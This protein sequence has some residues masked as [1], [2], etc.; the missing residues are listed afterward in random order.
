MRLMPQPKQEK[1]KQEKAKNP[2]GSRTARGNRNFRAPTIG[3]PRIKLPSIRWSH[4]F[5]GTFIAVAILLFL[6]MAKLIYPPNTDNEIPEDLIAP[7]LEAPP[8]SSQAQV[9]LT[10][11]EIDVKTG[12][13]MALNLWAENAQRTAKED[14]GNFLKIMF[15]VPELGCV[16]KY[17]EVMEN[18]PVIFP[19]PTT[20][21]ES[22]IHEYE[23][24]EIA[25][26][27][28]QVKVRELQ[29]EHLLKCTWENISETE[30]KPWDGLAP[31]EQEARARR[32]TR[33]LAQ[34]ID[35]PLLMS[36]NIA[37]TRG[38]GVDSQNNPEF[39]QFA[40]QYDTCQVQADGF[41]IPLAGAKTPEK[42]SKLWLNAY[43]HLTE[44]FNNITEL[45]FPSR[46]QVQ[47]ARP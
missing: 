34:S 5:K 45:I 2:E 36:T 8:I 30:T 20:R 47:P 10:R 11:E 37:A 19:E 21:E 24:Y 35:P 23:E 22:S 44:C 3:L 40:A 12:E 15:S 31:D 38:L 29:E 27:N 13:Y 17:R 6:L 28:A 14:P 32:A 18:R 46:P 39:A 1:A 41:A 43:Q 16:Q 26:V 33:L 25:T 42:M 4:I 7:E 9:S